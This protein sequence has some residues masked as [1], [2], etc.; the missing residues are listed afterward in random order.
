MTT[1]PSDDFITGQ[2]AGWRA[3]YRAGVMAER[4]RAEGGGGGGSNGPDSPLLG[5]LM[6]EWGVLFE[7]EVLPRMDPTSRAVLAQVNRAGRDA[8][9]LPADLACAGRTVGVKL[10]LADF[11]GSAGRLA[12]AKAN[13]CPWVA[14]TCALVA[15]VGDLD[16]LQ[17]ALENGCPWHART[18]W[19]AA[20]RGHLDMVE[21]LIADGIDLKYV[22]PLDGTT[23]QCKMV[24]RMWW[25]G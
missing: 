11:V 14:R 12:W 20:E 13:R 16:A 8:V 7:V 5:P 24:A 25:G 3:G 6:E 19:L 10:K 1:S 23:S 21:W 15:R 2:G 17:W 9:R 4:R 22:C 18:C